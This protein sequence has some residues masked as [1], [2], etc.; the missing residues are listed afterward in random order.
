[1]GSVI[2]T[3]NVASGIAVSP[4]NSV[5]GVCISFDDEL[6]LIDTNTLTELARVPVGDFPIRVTFSADSQT[7]FVANR[8]GNSVSVVDINGAASQQI[9]IVNGITA[10]LDIVLGSD[11]AFGYVGNFDFNAPSIRVFGTSTG[12][13]VNT[14][15]TNDPPRR[16]IYNESRDELLVATTGSEFLSYDAIGAS[17]NLVDSSPLTSAPSDMA[18][19]PISRAA[20]IALP[21]PDGTDLISAVLLGDV[22]LDGSVDVLDVSPFVTQIVVGIFQAEADINKDGSVNLLDVEPF[23]EILTSG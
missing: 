21:I 13:I 6:L 4:D 10:P 1:M 14:V 5:V 23:V 19:S 9:D 8:F 2:H 15:P 22:N 11:G 3:F 20:V 17:L 12:N 18:F 7:A 16:L